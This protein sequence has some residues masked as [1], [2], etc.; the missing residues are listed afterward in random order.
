ML[1]MYLF[2]ASLPLGAS[3]FGKLYHHNS[4]YN[5]TT[6]SGHL[7]LTPEP[8]VRFSTKL[9]SN[10]TRNYDPV[11]STNEI[12]SGDPLFHTMPLAPSCTEPTNPPRTSEKKQVFRCYRDNGLDQIDIYKSNVD[13]S[14]LQKWPS[15]RM[16]RKSKKYPKY[17]TGFAGL[18]QLNKEVCNRP[19]IKRLEMPVFMNGTEFDWTF[20]NYLRQQRKKPTDP[21]PVRAIYVPGDNGCNILCDILVHP[22]PPPFN[23]FVQCPLI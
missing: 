1:L 16:R 4:S 15:Y 17:F 18:S 2:V 5:T 22:M 20:Y 19:G 21:G 10:I 14:P 13:P 23:H 6:L 3:C 12:R 8:R 7:N 11:K 9:D